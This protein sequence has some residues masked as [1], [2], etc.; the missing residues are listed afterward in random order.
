MKHTLVFQSSVN[1]FRLRTPKHLLTLVALAVGFGL[2]VHGLSYGLAHLPEAWTNLLVV[3]VRNPFVGVFVGMLA[4]SLIQSSSLSTSILIALA[5]SHVLD[6]RAALPMVMGANIGTMLTVTIDALGVRTHRAFFLRAT[7]LVM[8]Q[9][10]LKLLTAALLLPLEYFFGCF[11][12][13]LRGLVLKSSWVLPLG[14][15]P[16]WAVVL[17]FSLMFVSLRLWEIRCRPWVGERLNLTRIF[18]SS[19]QRIFWEGLLCTWVLQSSAQV[20]ALFIPRLMRIQISPAHSLPFLMGTNLGTTITALWAACFVGP[21]ALP[22]AL[23]HV[24]F[25]LISSGIFLLIPA[26]ERLLVYLA[27]ALGKNILHHRLLGFMYIFVV[28][29]VIPFWL[30]LLGR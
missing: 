13:L 14:I 11:E 28:F 10:L 16:V 29:F 3:S 20:V 26:A 17:G 6:L 22:L 15:S 18:A 8:L 27:T 5:G 7:T 1:R 4:T 12:W 21:V 30:I 9:D 24:C 19:R 23:M 25:N 2:G